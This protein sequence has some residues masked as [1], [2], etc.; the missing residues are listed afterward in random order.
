MRK[1]PESEKIYVIVGQ[2]MARRR[3]E[4]GT[5]QTDLAHRCNLARGTIAN[6]EGARQR[7]TLHTLFSIAEALKVDIHT[8]L[9]TRSEV[10][11]YSGD[12]D[13]P[14]L[15]ARMKHV[16]GGSA[17]EVADFIAS[18]MRRDGPDA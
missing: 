5:S 14:L 2:R 8:L 7:P 1:P 11:Q 16:A 15:S 13:Q 18:R 6:I 12:G 10:E 17:A 3:Q 4:V 9:P